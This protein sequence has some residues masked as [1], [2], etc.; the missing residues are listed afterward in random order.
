MADFRARREHSALA[1]AKRLL[2]A[3]NGP[4]TD[5]DRQ[6]RSSKP[7]QVLPGQLDIFGGINAPSRRR[8]AGGA[9]RGSSQGEILTFRVLALRNADTGAEAVE[10]LVCERPYAPDDS[11]SL[12]CPE[13][14]EISAT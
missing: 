11:G 10:C 8:N 1:E 14:R 6:K 2:A 3:R 13:C 5:A 9:R 7:P 12:R 4:P